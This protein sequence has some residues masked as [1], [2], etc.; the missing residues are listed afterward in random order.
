MVPG[1]AVTREK[2]NA[3][4]EMT[5]ARLARERQERR[6]AVPVSSNPT[7]AGSG[8][9][10][11]ASASGGAPPVAA[12]EAPAQP[13]ASMSGEARYASAIS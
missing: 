12:E 2:A 6:E 8:D 13:A 7:A 1:G 9:P 5:D 3:D 4:E 10:M 11:P